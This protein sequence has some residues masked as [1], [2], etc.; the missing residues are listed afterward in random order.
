[1]LG[2]SRAPIGEQT[3]VAGRGHGRPQNTVQENC[4]LFARIRKA[5]CDGSIIQMH[6]FIWKKLILIAKFPV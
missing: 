3:H 4:L 1:M 6:Y 2:E 5:N